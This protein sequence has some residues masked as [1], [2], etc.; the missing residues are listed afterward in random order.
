M[1]VVEEGIMF[2]KQ[3]N[4]FNGIERG[5]YESIIRQFKSSVAN[6]GIREGGRGPGSSQFDRK[7]KF[8]VINAVDARAQG[9]VY[10]NDSDESS[11]QKRSKTAPPTPDA[12]LD[13]VLGGD[14]QSPVSKPQMNRS[15]SLSWDEYLMKAQETTPRRNECAPG[16]NRNALGAEIKDDPKKTALP[17]LSEVLKEASLEKFKGPAVRPRAAPPTVSLDYFDTYNPKDES[18][19]SGLLDSIYKTKAMKPSN[20]KHPKYGE[21]NESF[22]ML[23][24]CDMMT[25]THNRPRF[26]SRISPRLLE[27]SK[28]RRPFNHSNFPPCIQEK[29]HA[30][31]KINFPYESNYTYLNKTYLHDVKKYPEYLE[32]AHTLVELSQPQASLHSL[33]APEERFNQPLN[34]PL[35]SPAEASSQCGIAFLSCLPTMSPPSLA[36]YFH[37]DAE[38]IAHHEDSKTPVRES[39]RSSLPSMPA[40]P[41]LSTAKSKSETFKTSPRHSQRTCISCGSDQSPCWRP[42]WSAKEGQLCNSCGLRYKK[43]SA[44]CLNKKCRKIPAKG[45]WALMQSSKM[46]KFSDGDEGHACLDCGSKVEVRRTERS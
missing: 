17:S 33:H 25:Y 5:T 31:R 44:R 2:D 15:K 34:Q 1:S 7:R 13:W 23:P 40:T 19:R 41:P 29:V 22:T 12:S 18:W 38:T 16:M 32:L 27:N 46:V 30:R 45:E 3:Y 28:N 11:R 14:E 9:T 26:D 43:T 39:R 37:D 36:I 20:G 35:G 21:T 42:S 24:D 4:R 8:A 10:L 6:T